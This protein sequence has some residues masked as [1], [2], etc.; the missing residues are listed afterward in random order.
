MVTLG[1]GVALGVGALI[2][3]LVSHGIY[4]D[5]EASCLMDACDPARAGDRDQGEA[6]AVTSTVLTFTAGAAAIAALILFFTV[7]QD[8]EAEE[9]VAQVTSGPGDVGA[10]VA[11]RF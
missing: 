7:D 10:S 9:A 11:V 6:M 3:G 1:V 8:D 2:T 4:Q 5:L